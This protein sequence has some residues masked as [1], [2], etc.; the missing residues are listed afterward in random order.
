MDNDPVCGMTVA[1]ND[2]GGETDYQGK[3]YYFCSN[4]DK[5]T[6]DAAPDKFVIND[7]KL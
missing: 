7:K 5:K 4:D 2:V 6:F 3:T 1:R